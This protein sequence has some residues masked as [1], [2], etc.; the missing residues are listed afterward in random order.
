MG[1]SEYQGGKRG[2]R[3]ESFKVRRKWRENTENIKLCN[4]L[5]RYQIRDNISLKT[6]NHSLQKFL[7]FG[8]APKFTKKYQNLPKFTTKNLNLP[9]LRQI[10]DKKIFNLPKFTKIYKSSW[11]LDL[12]QKA[13]F[14]NSI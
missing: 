6:A 3:A 14:I 4:I 8:F 13:V 7:D 11:K 1:G 2:Y 10:Y 9:K 12:H 5:N